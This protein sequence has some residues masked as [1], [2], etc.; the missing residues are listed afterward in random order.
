MKQ[1]TRCACHKMTNFLMHLN[2]K[3]KQEGREGRKHEAAQIIIIPPFIIWQWT[4]QSWQTAIS[5][6]ESDGTNFN[7]M[8]A[9]HLF[10][11]PIIFSRKEWRI[12]IIIKSKYFPFYFLIYL[13]I[14]IKLEDTKYFGKYCKIYFKFDLLVKNGLIH[15]YNYYFQLLNPLFSWGYNKK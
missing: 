3:I 15:N 2:F 9:P 6:L 5:I 8:C 14:F 10:I 1:R 11:L 13:N 7:N 4:W 12:I